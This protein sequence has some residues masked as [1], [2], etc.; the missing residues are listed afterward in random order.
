MVIRG[1][2]AVRK[3]P[4]VSLYLN[5]KIIKFYFH[6]QKKDGDDYEALSRQKKFFLE[7]FE[8]S[9]EYIRISICIN[10]YTYRM[11]DVHLYLR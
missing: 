3:L 9:C 4:L 11:R 2:I 6:L 1:S 10:T 5:P 8:R 7:Y